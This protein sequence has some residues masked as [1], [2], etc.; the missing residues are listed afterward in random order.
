VIDRPQSYRE[1]TATCMIGWA[2]QR[3][4]KNG[5]LERKTFQPAVD[6]AWRAIKLRIGRDGRLVDVCTGTGKQTNMRAYWDR[7][8]ILGRDDRG[9]AMA[10]MFA[11]EV[12][13][14]QQ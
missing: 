13:A 9:G 6:R 12:L 1:F 14:S 7:P 4:M 8:A 5:W 3:G 11:T 2:M 10:I